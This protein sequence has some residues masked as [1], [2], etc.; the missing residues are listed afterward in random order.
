MKVVAF[1]LVVMFMASYCLAA[2][3]RR[4]MLGRTYGQKEQP[5]RHVESGKPME[6]SIGK[7]PGS[8]LDNHNIDNH[9]SIPRQHYNE[10]NGS[11]QEDG[12]D[13]GNG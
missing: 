5:H 3:P 7:Y 13:G 4:A 12:G 11:S 10:P 8:S 2:V 1:F 9:H 6:K